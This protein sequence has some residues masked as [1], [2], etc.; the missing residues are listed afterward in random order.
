M[1]D[2]LHARLLER[3]QT[4]ADVPF[5]TLVEDNAAI[6]S[7]TYRECL[8]RARRWAG[9]YREFGV[10]RGDR[11]VIILQHS[12]DLYANVLRRRAG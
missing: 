1:S 3:E 2:T 10:G 12:L 6:R 7:Y 11:V 5:L 8:V 9:T 4:A